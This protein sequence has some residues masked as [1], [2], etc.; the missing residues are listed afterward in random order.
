M[1]RERALK[2]SLNLAT[3]LPGTCHLCAAS[4]A[5]PSGT[6]PLDSP[7]AN[8]LGARQLDLRLHQAGC[9]T[10]PRRLIQT[11]TTLCSLK[12]VIRIP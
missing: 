8:R 5:W 6:K 2:K 1:N 11:T 10:H 4:M 12:R 3:V 7:L 9:W